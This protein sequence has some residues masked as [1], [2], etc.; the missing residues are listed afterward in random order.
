MGCN[1]NPSQSLQRLYAKKIGIRMLFKNK[2]KNNTR[3][4]F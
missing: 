2:I 4:W 1:P 3:G